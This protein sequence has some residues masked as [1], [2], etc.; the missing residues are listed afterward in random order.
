MYSRRPNP[1]FSDEYALIRT[2]VV[3]ARKNARVPQGEL[4]SRLGK[5][6][7]HIGMIERGQRRIDTLELYLIAEALGLDPVEFFQ[8]IARRL[9]GRRATAT[10]VSA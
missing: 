7:S 5:A 6:K 4:A 10:A 8:A 2:S 3:E 9:R 1:V